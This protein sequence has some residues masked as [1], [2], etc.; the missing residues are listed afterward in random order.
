MESIDP[1]S[2]GTY[3]IKNLS[4]NSVSPVIL[5]LIVSYKKMQL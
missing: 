5:D 3:S 2:I 4:A 1:I